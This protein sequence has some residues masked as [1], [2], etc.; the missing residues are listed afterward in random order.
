M[1]DTGC[2]DN[3]RWSTVLPQARRRRYV[4]CQGAEDNVVEPMSDAEAKNEM[5]G[6][7]FYAPIHFTLPFILAAIQ[8]GYHHR[9]HRRLFKLLLDSCRGLSCRVH[10]PRSGWR[11]STND[12]EPQQEPGL[13][14]KQ[15]NKI[16]DK[17]FTLELS[18]SAQ[19]PSLIKE[20]CRP[21]PEAVLIKDCCPGRP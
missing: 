9:L 19:S 1:A 2:R 8:R 17:C 21:P 6:S 18:E 15:K 20:C 10:R 3:C 14:S 11:H 5:N 16:H 4:G 12:D 7:V 13:P